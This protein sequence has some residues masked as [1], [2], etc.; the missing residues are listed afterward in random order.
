MRLSMI[1]AISSSLSGLLASANRLNNT[2]S[3]IANLQSAATIKDGQ[4]VNEP[5]V[6]N[7][8]INVSREEGGGSTFSRPIDNPS[9]PL[10]V[11][12]SVLANEQGIVEYPNILASLRE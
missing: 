6:P 11:P 12:N 2:A 8:I 9:I 10:Y 3:N 1:G 4:L 7:D 5:F